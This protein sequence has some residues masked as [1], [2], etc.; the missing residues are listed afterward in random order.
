MEKPRGVRLLHTLLVLY[1]R[2]ALYKYIRAA[3]W[4]NFPQTAL[5]PRHL[6]CE[7]SPQCR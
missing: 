2:V 6:D 3:F 4:I 5:D 1:Q 7:T